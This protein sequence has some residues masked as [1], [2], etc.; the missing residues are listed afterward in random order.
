MDP[1]P[2]PGLEGAIHSCSRRDSIRDGMN[3]GN[4]TMAISDGDQI[5]SIAIEIGG[6]IECDLDESISTRV[7]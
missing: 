4:I 1:L 5:A 2:I 6:E 3:Q 7:R